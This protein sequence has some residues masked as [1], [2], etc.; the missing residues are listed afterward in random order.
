VKFVATVRKIY[1]QYGVATIYVESNNGG[2]II[3][4]MLKRAGM[5]CV[6]VK[7]IKDK[8]TRLREYEGD[9]DQ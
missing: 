1:D 9:F 6:L 7:A 2:E 3:Y 5:S 8:V 4:R